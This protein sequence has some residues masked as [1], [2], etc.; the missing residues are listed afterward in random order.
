MI[1]GPE[2]S[3]RVTA[4]ACQR[5]L[6]GPSARS[7]SVERTST[8]RH[9]TRLRAPYANGQPH[10]VIMHI[11]VHPKRKGI[12][13]RS[14]ST[15]QCTLGER[16]SAL[17]LEARR[18]ALLERH[19][20]LE[21]LGRL[22]RLAVLDAVVRASLEVLVRILAAARVLL[23][24]LRERLARNDLLQ[25]RHGHALALRVPLLGVLRAP[26]LLRQAPLERLGRGNLVDL[27]HLEEPRGHLRKGFGKGLRAAGAVPRI[28]LLRRHSP[29]VLR[30]AFLHAAE[31]TR[32]AAARRHFFGAEEAKRKEEV[33]DNNLHRSDI[34]FSSIKPRKTRRPL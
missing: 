33:R 2:Q 11:S 31:L 22:A 27:D 24:D 19:T 30:G 10:S 16:A 26:G 17:G 25:A 1:R 13:T 15:P 12:R 21:H 29:G 23:A 8:F 28:F 4:R 14:S 20:R 7:F 9:N 34:D 32:V 5:Q 6:V 3:S 18:I